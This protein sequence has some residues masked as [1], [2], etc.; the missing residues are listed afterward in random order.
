MNVHVS[1]QAQ[2]KDNRDSRELM[3]R[4]LQ[5]T[6]YPLVIRR[7]QKYLFTTIICSSTSGWAYDLYLTVSLHHSST[8]YFPFTQ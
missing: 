8:L 4:T 2:A 3:L 5:L 7:F 1:D 6:E